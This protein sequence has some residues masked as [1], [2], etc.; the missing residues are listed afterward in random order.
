MYQIDKKYICSA[1][2]HRGHFIGIKDEDADY[3]CFSC[4]TLING[5]E[6]NTINEVDLSRLFFIG[7][8]IDTNGNI[9]KHV[10]NRQGVHIA[11]MTHN[12]AKR[13]NM[14][15]CVELAHG[16][17][18]LVASEPEVI[19]YVPVELFK[20][21]PYLTC[22]IKLC[23]QNEVHSRCATA[24]GIDEQKEEELMKNYYTPIFEKIS[25]KAGI[26]SGSK[27]ENEEKIKK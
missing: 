23:L 11:S 8:K 21:Y 16:I 14:L 26:D 1:T 20:A 3:D 6:V 17:G 10:F 19:D 5:K 18:K 27:K 24:T 25:E 12:N 15:E 4:L 13:L 7:I 22:H 2:E 9:I